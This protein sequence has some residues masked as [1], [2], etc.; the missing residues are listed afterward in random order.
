MRP[1]GLPLHYVEG[2]SEWDDLADPRLADAMGA[3]M[4]RT[5]GIG[6]VAVNLAVTSLVTNSWLYDGDERAGAWVQ[7]YVDGWA[8][9]ARANG[10]L[11]PDSVA[12]DGTV[13][14]SH[15]G[16]WY[17]GNYGWTWP[18]GL[19]SVGMGAIERCPGQRQPRHTRSRSGST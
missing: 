13:G 14:G 2:I 3:A 18:H 7:R 4:Q 8:E 12:P 19:A 16:R 9:R 17:G 6:D 1:Y 5:L 15:E 11:I 10:G